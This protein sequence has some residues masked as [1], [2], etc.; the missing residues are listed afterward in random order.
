M[1]VVISDEEKLRSWELL[2]DSVDKTDIPIEFV[3]G[4]NLEFHDPVE[5]KLAQDIDL[6]TMR[7][8]GFSDAELE[9]IMSQVMM[10]HNNNIKSVN[11]YLNVE[12]IAEIIGKHTNKLLNGVK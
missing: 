8:H 10:E 4:I 12:Y 7:E 11:F 9:E 1:K 5:G 3:Q 2:I 6:R